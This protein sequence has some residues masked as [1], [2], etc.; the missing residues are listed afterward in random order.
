MADSSSRATFGGGLFVDLSGRRGEFMLSLN[1]GEIGVGVKIGGGGDTA[2]AKNFLEIFQAA[3]PDIVVAEGV[4]EEMG[5]QLKTEPLFQ[6]AHEE[7]DGSLSEGV[8]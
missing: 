7:F 3:E 2:V 1:V 5:V 8:S 6:P 4:A